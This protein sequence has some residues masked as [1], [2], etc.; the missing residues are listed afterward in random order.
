[1]D[2][3]DKQTNSSSHL[4]SPPTCKSHLLYRPRLR[5]RF[6]IRQLP[7]PHI[8]LLK[9]FLL[10][11]FKRS[12]QI[13]DLFLAVRRSFS[14]GMALVKARICSFDLVTAPCPSAPYSLI[15]TPLNAYSHHPISRDVSLSRSICKI[16]LRYKTRGMSFLHTRAS[17]KKCQFETTYFL[18]W[19]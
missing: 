9:P 16:G 6:R 5:P 7:H 14:L 2:S 8:L 4:H 1:M 15:H 12:A 3:H 11:P 13:M 18:V 17:I 10:Q 19:C